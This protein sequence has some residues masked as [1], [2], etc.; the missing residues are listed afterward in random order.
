MENKTINIGQGYGE[1]RFG[2]NRQEIQEILGEPTEI[3]TF[4]YSEEDGDLTDV[5][6]YDELELSLSFDEIENW[7]LVSISISDTEATLNGEEF[8]GLNK[9]QLIERLKAN[10][11]DEIYEEEVET[12]EE[13]DDIQLLISVDEAAISFWFDGDTVNEIQFA[14]EME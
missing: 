11:L 6:H 2:M 12:G 4:S 8:I 14:T 3:D 7:Q 5:W 9:K 1:V 13:E 10:D